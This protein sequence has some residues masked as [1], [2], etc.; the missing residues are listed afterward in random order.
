MPTFAESERSI[1]ARRVVDLKEALRRIGPVVSAEALAMVAADL[2][3]QNAGDEDAR[4]KE[5][6]ERHP[7]TDPKEIADREELQ[8]GPHRNLA[9]LFRQKAEVLTALFGSYPEEIEQAIR[10]PSTE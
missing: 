2:F 6:E 7:T 8:L 5:I 1:I 4:I 3:R 9:K 10:P